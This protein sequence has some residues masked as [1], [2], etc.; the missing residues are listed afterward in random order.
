LAALVGWARRIDSL[1]SEVS[2][3]PRDARARP[4]CARPARVRPARTHAPPPPTGAPAAPPLVRSGDGASSR[5]RSTVRRRAISPSRPPLRD[6]AHSHL[7]VRPPGAAPISQRRACVR[8]GDGTEARADEAGARAGDAGA[9]RRVQAMQAR[10]GDAGACARRGR[11][12]AMQSRL[13]DMRANM[14]A[15]MLANTFTSSVLAS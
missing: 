1:D 6:L 13:A 12:Q 3:A 5:R 8:V 15:N 9:C 10:A 4:A 14:R 7:R 2:S 11:A